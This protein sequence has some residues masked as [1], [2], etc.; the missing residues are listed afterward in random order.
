MA[1]TTTTQAHAT[2]PLARAAGIDA[3][4][5]ICTVAAATLSF[6]TGQGVANWRNLVFPPLVVL[7]AAVTLTLVAAEIRAFR[8]TAT[9][10]SHKASALAEVAVALVAM[11]V[12]GPML[13]IMP[14]VFFGAMF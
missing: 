6:A 3:A 14:F 2:H 8:R 1:H 10:V 13:V 5:V 11:V 7:L 12:V 9:Q 4:I